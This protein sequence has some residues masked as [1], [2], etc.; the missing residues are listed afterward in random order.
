MYVHISY[1]VGD[2]IS[3]SI[4]IV[5]SIKNNNKVFY[6]TYFLL[7][8]WHHKFVLHCLR[9]FRFQTVCVAPFS[10]NVPFPNKTIKKEHMFFLFIEF[11]IF[12]NFPNQTKVC[13]ADS[14]LGF[15]YNIRHCWPVD[16]GMP[17]EERRMR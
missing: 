4:N 7:C 11:K 14:V 17:D 3:I 2:T 1:S 15:L 6:C 13:S 16:R 12:L 9:Q 5:E 8:W 10:V